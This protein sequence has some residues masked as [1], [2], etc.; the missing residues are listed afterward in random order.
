MDVNL[1]GYFAMIRES[2][3]P[4]LRRA[5]LRCDREHQLGFRLRSPI[6]G[7]VRVGEG[8][9][10]RSHPHRGQ[11]ARPL[12]RAVQRDPSVGTRDVDEGVRRPDVEVDN[13]HVGHA[14]RRRSAGCDVEVRDAVRSASS[15]QD[16]CADG[17]GGSAPTPPTVSTGGRSTSPATPSRGCS[18]PELRAGDHQAVSSTLDPLDP[19]RRR[20]WSRTFTNDVPAR[21]HPELQVFGP[22]SPVGRPT[23]HRRM[24]SRGCHAG[25][26]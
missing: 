13:A 14:R 26:D 22:Y 11:G 18:E 10:C 1:K 2:V 3:P 17:R 19:S 7:G 6:G 4:S 16:L 12:R 24:T 23:T 15:P 25:G 20:T 21:G 5:G 8:G 9:R